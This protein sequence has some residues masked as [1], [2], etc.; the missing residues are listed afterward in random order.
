MADIYTSQQDE[1]TISDVLR[2]GFSFSS[3]ST[4]WP[5]YIPLRIALAKSLQIDHPPE[6]DYDT[7]DIRGSE[8]S[9]EQLTGLSKEIDMQGHQDFDDAICGLMSIYHEE[10]LFSDQSSYKKWLQ[11][12]IRRGLYEIRSSW[13]VNHEFISWMKEEILADVLR[14]QNGNTKIDN[15]IGQHQLV[16]ALAE[17]GIRA[18]IQNEQEGIRITRYNALLP[19]LQSFD[20]LKRSVDKLGFALGL[21]NEGVFLQK[22]SEPRVIALDLPRNKNSWKSVPTENLYHWGN[23]AHSEELPVL[24]GQ[25]VLGNDF[26][27]DLTSCPHLFLAGT[28]GS[29]KSV[30]LHALL[31]SLITSKS[32]S[33]LK[34]A[35]ID[36][37][38]VELG[39]YQG[40]A[41]QYG[42]DI[43][44]IASDAM[45][46][47]DNIIDEMEDR[48][49]LFKD[50]GVKD[51]SYP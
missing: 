47:L 21:G 20:L 27:F 34:L 16:S 38:L 9:L 45:L 7:I 29:G 41:H 30:T 40:I 25:D 11:R 26:S 12:H 36:P 48:S 17:V 37:K 3:L 50:L 28:T 46:L 22:T 6:D 49:S 8:Y 1:Q 39:Q 2:Y 13:K 19:E 23:K 35:L 10:D 43:A 18:V 33:E 42:D 24:L 44:H 51:P 14:D 15:E 31:L 32:P 5:K 4:K